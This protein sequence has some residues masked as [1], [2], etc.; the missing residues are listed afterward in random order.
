M[1]CIT[2]EDYAYNGNDVGIYRSGAMDND[3]WT[4]E[5]CRDYCRSNHPTAKYFT[6]WMSDG[7]CSCKSSDEGRS[8]KPGKISGNVHC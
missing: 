2:E 3:I 6:Y 5:S 8:T 4:Y 7:R 1:S